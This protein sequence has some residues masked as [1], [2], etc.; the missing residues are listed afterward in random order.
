MSKIETRLKA[1]GLELPT[2]AK[3]VASYLPAVT[4]RGH[5]FISGQ[6]PMKD[7]TLISTGKVP[8]EV[9]IEA[10]REAARQCVLNGLAALKAELKDQLDRVEKLVRIA[11]YV[12]SNDDFHGQPQVANGASDLLE[13][14]LGDSGRHARAAVGVNALPLN[15]PVEIE[16]VFEVD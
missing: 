11:V 10:A 3:P 8:S 1:I 16:F 13:Q 2:P 15:A 12:Q 14:I 4:S 9:S 5:V 7:G 6:L